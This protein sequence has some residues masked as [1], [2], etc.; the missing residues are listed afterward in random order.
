[1]ANP[2]VREKENSRITVMKYSKI[3]LSVFIYCW[4]S[5]LSLCS[6]CVFLRSC[7][8]VEII[9]CDCFHFVKTVDQTVECTAGRN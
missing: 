6:G 1:M 4:I 3:C 5:V 8:S 2:A 9:F 7:L